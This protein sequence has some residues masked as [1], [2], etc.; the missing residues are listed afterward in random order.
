MEE[1]GGL[2]LYGADLY[3]ADMLNDDANTAGGKALLGGGEVEGGAGGKKGK[4]GK[5]KDTKKKT[6]KGKKGDGSGDHKTVVVVVDGT[7]VEIRDP[8]RIF[9]KKPI[10][11]IPYVS[12][13]LILRT[14]A[15]TTMCYCVACLSLYYTCSTTDIGHTNTMPTY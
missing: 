10:S 7:G 2:P 6:K 11:V 4:K 14:R 5:K 8:G 3:H 9:A 13:A 1:V 12:K 15:H